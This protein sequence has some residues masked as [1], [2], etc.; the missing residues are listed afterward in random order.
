VGSLFSALALPR[1]PVPRLAAIWHSPPLQR[2]LA[3]LPVPGGWSDRELQ[4]EY[5]S[6][7]IT[8]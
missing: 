2:E 1:M 5:L 3:I 6:L 8:G 7:A 4:I